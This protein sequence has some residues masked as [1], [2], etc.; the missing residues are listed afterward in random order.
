VGR[1][2]DVTDGVG[3]PSEVVH[4]HHHVAEAVDGGIELAMVPSRLLR[5]T[6]V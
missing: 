4:A 2:A 5:V 6:Y 1:L 3:H